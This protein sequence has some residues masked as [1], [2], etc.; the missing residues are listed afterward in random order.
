[1]KQPIITDRFILGR[2]PRVVNRLINCFWE[3]FPLPKP[4]TF[5]IDIREQL[6]YCINAFFGTFNAFLL[7]L[8]VLL[9]ISPYTPR[10]SLTRS[11]NPKA[12]LKLTSW[13]SHRLLQ[14]HGNQRHSETPVNLAIENNSFS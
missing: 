1:M 5:Y 6:K 11:T 7:G 3:F 14:C 4:H 9:T 8:I 2:N 12:R 10:Y 13:R